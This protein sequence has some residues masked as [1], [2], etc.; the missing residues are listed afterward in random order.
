MLGMKKEDKAADHGET[1][2][3]TKVDEAPTVPTEGEHINTDAVGQGPDD[4]VKTLDNTNIEGAKM[5][6]SDIEV[7]GD[8]DLFQL[9]SKASSKKEGWMKSTKVMSIP[10]VGCVIQVTTQQGDNVAVALTFVPGCRV[11]KTKDSIKIAKG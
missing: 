6:V 4:T 11:V 9:I 2:S 8:G 5:S 3:A 7:F 10:D 1:I